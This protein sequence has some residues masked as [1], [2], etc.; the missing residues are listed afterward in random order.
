MRDLPAGPRAG[1]MARTPSTYG[2]RVPRFPPGTGTFIGWAP[3]VR[4]AV[5]VWDWA[6]L[7]PAAAA[8]LPPSPPLCTDVTKCT[9]PAIAGRNSQ[10]ERDQPSA[11]PPA[12]RGH[13]RNG[14]GRVGYSRDTSA[15]RISPPTPRYVA[16]RLAGPRSPQEHATDPESHGGAPLTA[17]GGEV[18]GAVVESTSRG[19][20]R[21]QVETNAVH[22]PLE[23]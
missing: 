2:P 5:T 20:A 19:P 8:A 14:V 1:R 13:P 15:S 10:L 12:G 11:A 17:E 22:T 18:G 16:T 4:R 21:F 23:P 9:I 3:R 7:H 6:G